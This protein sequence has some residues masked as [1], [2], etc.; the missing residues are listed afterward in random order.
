MAAP[1][2][3]SGATTRGRQAGRGGSFRAAEYSAAGG[4]HTV[5]CKRRSTRRFVITEKLLVETPTSGF[6][7]ET[8]LRNYAKR[9]LTPR[10]IDM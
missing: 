7:F 3:T 6:T 9:T 4:G 1:L 5:H 8:L 10:Y 2:A